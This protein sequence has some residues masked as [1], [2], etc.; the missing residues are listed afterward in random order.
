MLIEVS[1]CEKWFQPQRRAINPITTEIAQSKHARREAYC[2]VIGGAEKPTHVVSLSAEWVSVSFLDEE[3]REYLRYDFKERTHGQM[4]LA[5]SI[6]R[7]FEGA[8]DNVLEAT[9][10]AFKEDGSVLME[11]RRLRTQEVGERRWQ[12]DLGGNWERYP[13]FGEY[14]DICRLERELPGDAADRAGS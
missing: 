6:H 5:A 1:F 2:A 9:Q 12:G 4:F 11:K 3:G 7:T 14:A 13:K 10:F 8:T